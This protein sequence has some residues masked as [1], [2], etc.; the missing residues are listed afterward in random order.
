[1]NARY[2]SLKRIADSNS[3]DLSAKKVINLATFTAYADLDGFL[4]WVPPVFVYGTERYLDQSQWD[5]SNVTD[6][7]PETIYHSPLSVFRQNVHFIT[8]D[9]GTMRK[10]SRIVLIPRQGFSSRMTGLQLQLGNSDGNIVY[11]KNLTSA[12]SIYDITF[13]SPSDSPNAPLLRYNP[14][15]FY[16]TRPGYDS[17]NDRYSLPLRDVAR[18]VCAEYGADLASYAEIVAAQ[19]AGAQWCA[20]G[21][22]ADSTPVDAQGNVYGM[23]FPMQE[24]VSGC[25]GGSGVWPY[26]PPSGRGGAVCY[27]V[28]PPVEATKGGDV[29]WNW[30]NKSGAPAAYYAPAPGR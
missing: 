30:T 18:N 23:A 28:K 9:L 27:G 8:L 16:V 21:W 29:I 24:F 10:L 14:E 26:V 5:K 1:V 20:T 22:M 11:A 17:I 3:G 15:V 6:D 4:T 12:Q 25:G 19:K 2:V 7:N 13:E